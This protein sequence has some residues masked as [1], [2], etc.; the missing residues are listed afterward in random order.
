MVFASSKPDAAGF[1]NKAGVNFSLEKKKGKN[2]AEYFR[3]GCQK[4]RPSPWS[5]SNWEEPWSSL[6]CF[7]QKYAFEAVMSYQNP[8]LTGGQ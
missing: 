1:W 5:Q 6:D 8:V 2:R 7:Q 3:F 4:K